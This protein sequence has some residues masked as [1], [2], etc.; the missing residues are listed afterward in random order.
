MRLP[1]YLGQNCESAKHLKTQNDYIQVCV[2]VLSFAKMTEGPHTFLQRWVIECQLQWKI[3]ESIRFVFVPFF[4][5]CLFGFGQYT[6]G[7]SLS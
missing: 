4:A 6:L 7:E 2:F 3:V 5:Y 1:F